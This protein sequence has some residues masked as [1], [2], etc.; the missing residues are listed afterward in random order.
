[1]HAQRTAVT[2]RHADI[3]SNGHIVDDDDDAASTKLFLL[4]RGGITENKR[5]GER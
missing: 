3:S 4:I 2:C 5:A 1:M